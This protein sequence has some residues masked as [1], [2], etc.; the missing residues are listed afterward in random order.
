MTVNE[1]IKNPPTGYRVYMYKFPNGKIYIGQTK[2]YVYV[3]FLDKYKNKS[4]MDAIEKYGWKNIELTILADGLSESEANEEEIKHI[5]AF[6]ACNPEIGYNISK[7]GKLGMIGL[8]HSEEARAKMSASGIGKHSGEKNWNYGRRRTDAEKEK[9]RISHRK[10]MP[11]VNQYD[12][13][14]RFLR[15]YESISEA[16]RVNNTTPKNIRCCIKGVSHHAC[17]YFWEYAS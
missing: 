5:A 4:L 1:M 15:R 17:G 8:K 9:N 14:G 3:R 13:D 6:D 10:S 7:G 16:A 12:M 2:R 11:P